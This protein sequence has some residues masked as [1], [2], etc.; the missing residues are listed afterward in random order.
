LGSSKLYEKIMKTKLIIC[1]L[2]VLMNFTVLFAQ[3]QKDVTFEKITFTDIGTI[4]IPSIM[5]LQSGIYKDLSNSFSKELG[6]D[7]SGTIIYQQK[8]L[9]SFS[10]PA[11][12]YARV[13]LKETRGRNSEFKTLNTKMSLTSK[14]LKTLDEYTKSEMEKQFVDTNLGMKLIKWFGVSLEKL[15]GN[16]AIPTGLC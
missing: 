14:Q 3:N 15:N 11:N 2:L 7:S 5:E 13:M 6:L 10:K 16:N 4:S 9:N 1:L 8:G 12:T